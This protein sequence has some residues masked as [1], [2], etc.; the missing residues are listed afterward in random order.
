M[1]WGR[2]H[3]PEDPTN[4][5]FACKTVLVTGANS[6]L[7]HEAAVKYAALGASTLILGIRTQEKGEQAKQDIAQRTKGS[8]NIFVIETVDLSTF[9]SVRDCRPYQRSHRQTACRTARRWYSPV[10]IR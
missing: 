4:L 3:P 1:W 9:A 5:S 10:G 2:R 7:G 6:G 8:P